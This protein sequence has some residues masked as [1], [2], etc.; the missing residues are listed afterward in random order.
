VGGDESF[1]NRISKVRTA[2][3]ITNEHGL[4]N[5]ISTTKYTLLSWLPMSIAEQFRRFA[6]IY[7]IIVVV[8]MY[9]GK[10]A[11]QIYSTPLLP[12][13]TAVTLFLVMMVTSSKEGL[14][15]LQRAKFDHEENVRGCEIITF[16][17]EGNEVVTVK[18]TQNICSG[19]VVKLTGATQV[20]ADMVLILT[21]NWDDGNRCFI[22]TANLDGETNLKV[23]EAPAQLLPTVEALQGRA[24][25]GLFDGEVEF[26]NPNK[27]M[28][29]F[30]GALHLRKLEQQHEQ[31]V[32]LGKENVLLR[33]S[34]FSN[35]EWAYGVALYTGQECKVLAQRYIITYPSSHH[36][37]DTPTPRAIITSNQAH[38]WP[39]PLTTLTSQHSPTPVCRV[40]STWTPLAWSRSR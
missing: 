32:P 19:D 1:Q 25:R 20:P 36:L 37:Q 8:M 17:A 5:K 2:D 18:E 35:T 13:S 39:I 38:A 29:N 31:G 10:Y 40:R 27:N 22:E 16:D 12:E 30:V 15:D 24:S 34:L 11:P 14:E 21:S 7:F 3:E 28:H 9:I 4:S 23:R 33:G 6:N 26:E